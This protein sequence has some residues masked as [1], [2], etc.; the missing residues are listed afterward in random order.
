MEHETEAL[1]SSAA[2]A[3]RVG[4]VGPSRYSSP[5]AGRN[6]DSGT[7]D[8]R[9]AQRRK[10]R[11]ADATGML[12]SSPSSGRCV[13]TLT[14]VSPL[15]SAQSKRSDRMLLAPKITSR[16]L[17]SPVTML[18]PVIVDSRDR[19]GRLG[20]DR[21]LERCHAGFGG[22]AIVALAAAPAT[23]FTVSSL[24]CVPL[25][26]VDGHLLVRELDSRIAERLDDLVVGDAPD[27]ERVAARLRR[28]LGAHDDRA[29]LG[30]E[31][32]L[33]FERL[34]HV[35]RVVGIGGHLFAD[36]LHDLLHLLDVRVVREAELHHVDDPVAAR[37]AQ[38]LD[39]AV[40][41]DVERAAV[42]AQEHRAH[43]DLLDREQ[44]GFCRCL[45]PTYCLRSE[46]AR[47]R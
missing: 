40:G 43:V 7:I 8:R 38:P 44:Y 13:T 42:V 26:H 19:S 15:A 46:S 24:I 47:T 11:H 37:V 12:R 21:L 1:V 17:R 41:Q 39:L 29:V 6:A 2:S 5:S 32:A 30:R 28:E 18:A 22:S 31:H 36:L 20:P 9:R 14:G 25:R 4:V 16:S 33:G 3:A 45:T 10:A 27:H 23:A 35:G 34:Q